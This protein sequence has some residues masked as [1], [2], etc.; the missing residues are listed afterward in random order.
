MP[1][2]TCTTGAS[3]NKVVVPSRA[4]PLV[5]PILLFTTTTS[6]HIKSQNQPTS[7]RFSDTLIPQLIAAKNGHSR[8]MRKLLVQTNIDVDRQSQDGSTPLLVSR[9]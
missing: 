6:F 9:H 7:P 1:M 2:L 8:T 3:C 5:V 4:S